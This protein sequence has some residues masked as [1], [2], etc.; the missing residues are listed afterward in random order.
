MVETPPQ[1]LGVTAQ[2]SADEFEKVDGDV[3]PDLTITDAAALYAVSA[4]TLRRLVTVGDLPAWKVKGVRGREWRL[5][6]EALEQAG[7]TRRTA[8]ATEDE[9][10]PSEV[11]RLA[12]VLAAERA[13][14]AR[15]D[16]QLGYALLTVG[17]LR[18]RLRDAG[19]DPDELFGADLEAGPEVGL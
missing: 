3:G 18:G 9:R 4:A 2:T 10:E 12:E 19:I 14:S 11:R 17:R 15:L 8:N 16:S 5:S 7:F 1:R 13:R 6:T